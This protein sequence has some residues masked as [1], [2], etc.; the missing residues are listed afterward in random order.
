MEFKY[1]QA[2]VKIVETGS[3]SAAGEALYISQPTISVRIQQLE[4]ELNV[5]LFVRADGKKLKLT[6][7]GEKV[8]PMFR[9]ALDLIE[10][11]AVEARKEAEQTA[12]V[13]ISCPNHMGADIMPEVLNVLYTSFP[14]IDFHL[15]ID[16]IRNTVE[17]VRTGKVDIGLIY[18]PS[19]KQDDYADINMVRIA[20]ERNILVCSPEHPLVRQK[21]KV[22]VSSLK[23][24]RIIIYD[25]DTVSTKMI[26]QFLR[27]NGLNEYRKVEIDNLTWIQQMVRKG[28]GIAFMQKAQA[29]KEISNQTLVEIPLKESLPTTTVYLLFH[30][31]LKKEIR[32][33]TIEAAKSIFQMNAQ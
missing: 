8:Y 22:S 7:F 16:R 21:R 28:L 2:F 24:E 6:P 4:K 19:H 20:D 25:R 10:K 29:R 18:A 30:S 1:M 26:E 15:K 23:N 33:T 27:T 11:I 14:S 31:D 3:F 32:E 9:Q 5:P 12:T 17:G 13:N